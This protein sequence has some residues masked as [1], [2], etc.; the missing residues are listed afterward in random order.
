MGVVNFPI[1]YYQYPL[2]QMI[3]MFHHYDYQKNL[4]VTPF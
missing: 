3:S 1:I 4:G 2:R